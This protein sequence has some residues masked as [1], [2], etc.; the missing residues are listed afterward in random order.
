MSKR[1]LITGGSGFIGSHL[2]RNWLEDGHDIQ[3]LSRRPD[4]VSRRWDFRITA[5]DNLAAMTG[6][7]DW[8]VNLAGEGIAD[9]RW[10]TARQ[11]VLRNSRIGVTQSLVAWAEE[12]D[13]RFEA[14]LSG[15]AIGVYG[16]LSGSMDDQTV[17]ETSSPAGQDFAARLCHDWEYAA[18]PLGALTDRLIVLR[19]GVVLGEHAGMLK[20]LWAPFN[21]G[22]GGVIGHGDQYLSWIHIR[23]YTR[24]MDCLL[25]S[26]VSGPV[27]MTAPSPVTNRVFTETLAGVLKR[28]AFLP[29]PTCAAK[30]VFGD[31]SDLLLKGQR[32]LPE[33]LQDIGFQYDYSDIH[34]ALEAVRAA[35]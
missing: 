30:L 11:Q 16:A 17:S 25:H 15:S 22:L 1:I 9:Q 2:I 7:F 12:N 20:R 31:M 5:Y 27:N 8:L 23:D 29:M 19:T 4:E 3:V 13:Q 10:T 28:P 18:Q 33:R 6:P 14:V 26:D 24:A 32:V 35:W 21:L 34:K